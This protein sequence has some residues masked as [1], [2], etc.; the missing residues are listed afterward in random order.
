MKGGVAHVTIK[1]KKGFRSLR[2]DEEM[3][4]VKAAIARVNRGGLVRIVEFSVMSNHVHL[5]VEAENSGDLSKGMASLNTGLG[6]RLNRLWGRV[7]PGSVFA[8][9]FH[10]EVITS[11]TQMRNV[12]K[13]VLRNDVH[14]GLGLGVLDPCSSAMSFGGFAERRGASKVDCVSV[15]A[16]SWLLR[17]GWMKGGGRGLLTIHDIPRVTGV[18][19]A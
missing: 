12:L 10:L 3:A 8:E 11:P 2:M 19:Q 16:R 17:T 15:E 1:P 4:V 13:Y 14:H 5:I 6:M 18:L 7:R 9:R